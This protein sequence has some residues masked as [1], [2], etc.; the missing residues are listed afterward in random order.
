MR[1]ELYF[2]ESGKWEGNFSHANSVSSAN[3][4]IEW[5]NIKLSSDKRHIEIN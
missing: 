2:C 1:R 5:C 3:E 4:E